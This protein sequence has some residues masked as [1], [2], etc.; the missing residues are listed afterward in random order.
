MRFHPRGWWS[1]WQLKNFSSSFVSIVQ[2]S[3]RRLRL[4]GGSLKAC[5]S[6]FTAA[7]AAVGFHDE[8]ENYIA[9]I[10]AFFCEMKKDEG[11][12]ER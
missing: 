7:T 2:Q 1:R 6:V 3:R 9:V 5:S 12:N 10:A 4:N 8:H 11:K